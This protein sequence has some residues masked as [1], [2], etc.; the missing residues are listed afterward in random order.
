MKAGNLKISWRYSDD[1]P[2]VTACF[3]DMDSLP[4]PI[5]QGL[6]KCVKGD[7]FCRDTGRKLSL[8]RALKEANLPKEE[9]KVIWE[10]YRNTKRGGRW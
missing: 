10:L 2:K 8:S 3:I 9:R 1:I 6:A 4:F 5:A 7:H